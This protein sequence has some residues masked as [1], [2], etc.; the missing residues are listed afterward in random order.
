MP[1]NFDFG[2]WGFGMGA[3][4]FCIGV[5]GNGIFS[6]PFCPEI[7][8]QCYI[9]HTRFNILADEKNIGAFIINHHCSTIVIDI[10]TST[11][12]SIPKTKMVGKC[13]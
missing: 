5:L 2:G 1:L 4:I 6:S 7:G 12:T 11:R 8:E 10:Q 9:G 13:R 3:S